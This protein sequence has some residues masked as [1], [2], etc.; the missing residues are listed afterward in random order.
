MQY[1]SDPYSKEYIASPVETLKTGG[2]DCEDGTLLLG[3]MLESIGVDTR[4]VIIPGH[5]FL[6]A[7]I[8][9]AS[10]KDK[11]NGWVYMDWTCRECRFGEIPY[12]DILHLSD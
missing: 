7:L 8:P 1:V 5:A 11:I 3:A 12:K 6:K 4:I 2:G 9:E 10:N